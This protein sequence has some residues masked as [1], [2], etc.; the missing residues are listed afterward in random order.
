MEEL[1]L[2]EVDRQMQRLPV[3]MREYVSPAEV[4]AYA[5]NRLPPLYATSQKG[6]RAQRLRAKNEA[7]SQ[8]V[9]AVRQAMVAVQRDPLRVS[10]P[11]PINLEGMQQEMALNELREILQQDDIS[12]NNLAEIIEQT[13]VKTARGQISWHKRGSSL[14]NQSYDWHD[15][16]RLL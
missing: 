6:W 14:P 8:V 12:W 15:D 11:L 7:S 16:R 2:E 3:A 1:V 5:L 10:A 9:T 13:L 4:A